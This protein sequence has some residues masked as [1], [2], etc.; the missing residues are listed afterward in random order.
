MRK[1]RAEDVDILPC[2][3]P[4]CETLLR[5]DARMGLGLPARCALVGCSAPGTMGLPG[6]A[7]KGKGKCNTADLGNEGKQHTT[8]GGARVGGVAAR[9]SL[10]SKRLW[11]CAECRVATPLPLVLRPR[12]SEED[13]WAASLLP[14]HK[15]DTGSIKSV[16]ASLQWQQGG[17]HVVTFLS[18][19]HEACGQDALLG[20]VALTRGQSRKKTS[21]AMQ[22]ILQEPVV[23]LQTVH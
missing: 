6:C 1:S 7:T 16:E 8:P 20:P 15:G 17:A 3:M 2:M 12:G 21:T 9:G 5:D 22:I 11:R 19:S 14:S 10:P 23:L 18:A 4:L 13:L